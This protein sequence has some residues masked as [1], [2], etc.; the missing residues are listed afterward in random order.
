[1]TETVRS[2]ISEVVAIEVLQRLS[3]DGICLIVQ[4][5]DQGFVFADKSLANIDLVDLAKFLI[6]HDCPEKSMESI[7]KKY[8]EKSND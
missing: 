7:L 2:R 3:R 8:E 6:K 1:M 5:S 4:T